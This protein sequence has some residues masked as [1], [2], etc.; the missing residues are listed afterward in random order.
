MLEVRE[1]ILVYQS[2]GAGVQ[3][4][5]MY[6]LAV[7]LGAYISARILKEYKLKVPPAE[8]LDRLQRRVERGLNE[9]R[10]DPQVAAHDR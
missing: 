8:E 7:P 1:M 6:V 4:S 5:A 3:S 10:P 9:L 2:L